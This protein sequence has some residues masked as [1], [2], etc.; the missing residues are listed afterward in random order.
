MNEPLFVDANIPMYAHGAEHPY[1]LPC[2]SALK[3]IVA[4]KIPTVISSEIVQEII[5]RYLSL[6][7]PQQGIQVAQDIMTVVSRVL[8]V[9]ETD[10]RHALRLIPRYPTLKARDLIHVAVMLENGLSRILS[11]DAHFD[12]VS[13]VERIDPRDFASGGLGNQ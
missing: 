9:T 12:G 3:R 6:Q 2:Q 13:E 8:P 10:V 4:A 5:H 1:R 11:T 7:R